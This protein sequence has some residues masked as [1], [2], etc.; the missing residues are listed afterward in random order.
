ME[1]SKFLR[2][3]KLDFAK[4]FLLAFIAFALDF[5]QTTFIPALDVSAETKTAILVVVA[6]LAKNFF[7]KPIEKK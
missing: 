2:W 6:Y 1:Q 4:A 3:N 7:T 5:L